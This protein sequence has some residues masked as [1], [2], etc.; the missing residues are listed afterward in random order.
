MNAPSIFQQSHNA[1]FP[2]F[3]EVKSPTL[4]HRILVHLQERSCFSSSPEYLL[5]CRQKHNFLHAVFNMLTIK[6]MLF[7]LYQY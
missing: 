1:N 5:Q 6:D 3:S 7:C 2:I 4:E